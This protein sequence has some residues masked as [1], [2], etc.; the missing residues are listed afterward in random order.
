LVIK[1]KAKSIFLDMAETDDTQ[2]GAN[3]YL[4]AY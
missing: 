3:I 2:N 4:K 1:K